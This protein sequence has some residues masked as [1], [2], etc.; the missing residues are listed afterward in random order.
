MFPTACGRELRDY[1]PDE[2]ENEMDSTWMQQDR[3]MELRARKYCYL[4]YFAPFLGI[5]LQSWS[6]A[7]A[8][9]SSDRPER[10]SNPAWREWAAMQELAESGSIVCPPPQCLVDDPAELTALINPWYHTSED[11]FC[12]WKFCGAGGDSG[13]SDWCRASAGNCIKCNATW[14]PADTNDFSL[15]T[16]VSQYTFQPFIDPTSFDTTL[17]S[18]VTAY[19]VSKPEYVSNLGW[20]KPGIPLVGPA[21]SAV[22]AWGISGTRPEAPSAYAVRSLRQRTMEAEDWVQKSQ[23]QQ[24]FEREQRSIVKAREVEYKARQYCYLQYSPDVSL[25]T[26]RRR[27][28]DD[29]SSGS[30]RLLG[31][32]RA[33]SSSEKPDEEDV[34]RTKRDDRL[35]ETLGVVWQ[36]WDDASIR[37]MSESESTGRIVCPD[38]RCYGGNVPATNAADAMQTGSGLLKGPAVSLAEISKQGP[39]SDPAACTASNVT[40]APKELLQHLQ[41]PGILFTSQPSAQNS[42]Q[43]SAPVPPR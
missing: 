21:G 43:A 9:E 37:H 40:G 3:D 18:N 14:C 27:K 15:R 5:D 8:S 30:R 2:A 6:E 23:E 39:A 10:Y 35:R 11:G 24:H 42:T 16:P 22:T 20:P 32:S 7:E 17:C 29:S 28:A 26:Y 38:P 19:D 4:S 12:S 13:G 25:S 41:W 1:L 34:A 33:G 31:K 36:T